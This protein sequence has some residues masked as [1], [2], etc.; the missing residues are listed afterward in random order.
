MADLL[1][2][3]YVMVRGDGSRLG[4]DL[5][6]IGGKVKGFFSGLASSIGGI[7]GQLGGL[8]SFLSIG[9][10]LAL[11]TREMVAGV[12]AADEQAAADKRLEAV[13]K[14]TGHA[15]GL[16]GEELRHHA[17]Q[18]QYTTG[19][20]DDS[21]QNFQA[22]LLTF[23]NVQGDTFKQ[24]TALALDM[25]AVMGTD[26][27]GAAVQLGK[28]LND[29]IQGLTALTRV[30]VSFSD[31]QKQ[32]VKTLVE[33]GR[34]AE[35]QSVIL[36]ELR[37]EFGGAA[38]AM[39][40]GP[41]GNLKRL[42]SVLGEMREELGAAL[43]PLRTLATEWQIRFVQGLTSA[44]P[45]ITAVA[46][47]ISESF[48]FIVGWGYTLATNLGTVWELI[49]W[50]AESCA[51]FLEDIFGNSVKAIQDS[52]FALGD[53]IVDLF[54][55]L[56]TI[57][58]Q[59]ARGSRDALDQ[60]LG[61]ALNRQKEI[62]GTI[63]KPSANTLL[64]MNQAA[65]LAAELA[66][67]KAALDSADRNRL[68]LQRPGERT[69]DRP[70][71]GAQEFNKGKAKADAKDA[72]RDVSGF[73]G[74]LELTKRLQEAFLKKDDKLLGVAEAQKDIQVGMAA[75]LKRLADKPALGLAMP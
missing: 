40:Q 62:A 21:I 74:P 63:L 55:Q 26:V 11:A 14:A 31:Q 59:A 56:P 3:A 70:G 38:E 36:G 52:F 57:V 54:G 60:V 65:M 22:V 17:A 27:E 35:A 73:L 34:G 15:A 5:T 28:A 25:A 37:S 48:R 41:E 8:G 50:S 53:S 69:F 44:M 6:A 30:G 67:K 42:N 58:L 2:T 4:A 33:T 19:V 45:V 20:A 75:D 18:L 29:P 61:D 23:K 12:A 39:A 10:G 7:T 64:A 9:G 68:T 51:L 24:A 32:L 13:L 1:G 43:I 16:S 66:G 71:A 72:L 46:E 49:Q 47:F